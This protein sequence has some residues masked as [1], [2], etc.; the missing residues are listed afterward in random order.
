M[1]LGAG[2]GIEGRHKGRG[3]DM[4]LILLLVLLKSDGSSRTNF[5][6]FIRNLERSEAVE[7]H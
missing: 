5:N 2:L 6:Y 7:Q 3:Y 4:K 1:F